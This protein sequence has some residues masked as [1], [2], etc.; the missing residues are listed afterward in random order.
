MQET[1]VSF[2]G[3]EDP[4]EQEMATHSSVLAWRISLTEKP[5]RLQSVGSQESDTTERPS[6]QTHWQLK[7]LAVPPLP[8]RTSVRASLMASWLRSCLP[9]QG[10]QIRSLGQEGPTC[11]GATKPIRHNYWAQ[12]RSCW[13]CAP[14]AYAPWEKPPQWEATPSTESSPLTKLE[15]SP[16]SN[17]DL[18]QPKT[19]F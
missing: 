16:R 11:H 18:A 17:K 7:Q 1:Q 6:S 2:L 14:R 3:Q 12:S 9:M 15:K 13:A 10:T 19:I 4:L 8:A 5:G